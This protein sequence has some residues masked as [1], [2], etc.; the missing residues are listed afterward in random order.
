MDHAIPSI[1]PSLTEALYGELAV[2]L[3]PT[4]R[5][6][7]MEGISGVTPSAVLRFSYSLLTLW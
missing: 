6:K 2:Y 3:I 5:M 4:H 7:G 1:P